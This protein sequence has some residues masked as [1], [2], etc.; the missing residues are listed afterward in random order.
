MDGL[1]ALFLTVVVGGGLLWIIKWIREVPFGR[2]FENNS[3]AIIRIVS[4]SF[5][6]F[7]GTTLFIEISSEIATEFFHWLRDLSWFIKI[8]I[9]IGIGVYLERW[10][11]NKRRKR[12]KDTA[13]RTIAVFPGTYD[14]GKSYQYYTKEIH[15]ANGK[16]FTKAELDAF[17][18]DMD[19][20][21]KLDIM[22]DKYFCPPEEA[23]I[24]K[25]ALAEAEDFKQSN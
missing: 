14:K 21:R 19:K 3:S 23:T 15:A 25:P 8:P 16:T 2:S 10:Y 4:F 11:D 20:I 6:V 9:F 13:T 22:G 7:L 24:V 18:R 5:L 1:Q 12:E 17:D